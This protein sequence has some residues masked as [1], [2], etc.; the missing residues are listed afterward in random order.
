M[1]AAAD[2]P[3]PKKPRKKG[4]RSPSA[5]KPAA[6]RREPKLEIPSLRTPST[7]KLPCYLLLMKLTSEGARHVD[8]IPE[9]YEELD[10][11]VDRCGGHVAFYLLTMGPY[12]IAA[13]VFVPDDESAMILA[14]RL[15]EQG[16][17]TTLTMKAF[18]VVPALIPAIGGAR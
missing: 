6:A 10:A 17:V 18:D 7:E 9:R 12:D 4:D 14:L 2:G 1:S 13:A 5:K 16:Y 11:L 15:T 8:A 3:S